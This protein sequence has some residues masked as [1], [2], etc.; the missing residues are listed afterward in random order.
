M[1]DTVAPPYNLREQ[2]T[3]HTMPIDTVK[4][5]RDSDLILSPTYVPSS[6]KKRFY[7]RWSILM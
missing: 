4:A 1:L 7:E 3:S 6:A 2:F 5:L